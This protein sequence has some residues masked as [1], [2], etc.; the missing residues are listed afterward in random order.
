[1]CLAVTWGLQ[2]NSFLLTAFHSQL[3]VTSA[4]CMHILGTCVIARS[5]QN[6]WLVC[7]RKQRIL[8]DYEAC[9][10]LENSVWNTVG[11]LNR[12]ESVWA[13]AV[14]CELASWEVSAEWPVSILFGKCSVIHACVQ[15]WR[16]E[17][18]LLVWRSFI[19]KSVIQKL[20]KLPSRRQ[21]IVTVGSGINPDLK[22]EPTVNYWYLLQYA[23]YN[24]KNLL[25]S[26]CF[27]RM[28]HLRRKWWIHRIFFL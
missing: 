23:V 19:V 4:R 21:L 5:V 7:Q 14:I 8:P 18:L 6:I 20:T 17:Q 22:Q 28:V 3:Q 13:R 1:M 11:P 12:G 24:S 27:S 10:T 15:M 2:V 16:W 26:P 25:V 9:G